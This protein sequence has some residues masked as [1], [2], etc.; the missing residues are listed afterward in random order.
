[1]WSKYILLLSAWVITILYKGSPTRTPTNTHTHTHICTYTHTHTHTRTQQEN[2]TQRTHLQ[3]CLGL[4]LISTTL[5]GGK[6]RRQ[7]QQQQQQQQPLRSPLLPLYPSLSRSLARSPRLP[8]QRPSRVIVARDGRGSGV[9]R[10]ACLCCVARH[11]TDTFHTYTRR[12]ATPHTFAADRP[13]LSLSF[14]SSARSV[15]SFVWK[16]ICSHP[17]MA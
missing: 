11:H 12:R 5:V 4:Q 16:L 17:H 13:L 6:N 9:V 15:C 8:P 3:V 2:T 14:I 1:M 10:G 7:Q